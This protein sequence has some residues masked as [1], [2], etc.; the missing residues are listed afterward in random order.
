MNIK[1]N[2]SECSVLMGEGESLFLARFNII[3]DVCGSRGF[4]WD[5]FD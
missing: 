1:R 2:T 3:L 4:N 5:L